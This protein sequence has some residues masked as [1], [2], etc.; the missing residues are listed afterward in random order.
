MHV[1]LQSEHAPVAIVTGASSG[2][3]AASARCLAAAGFRVVLAAR[4]AAELERI[5]KEI[6]AAGG[7][8]LPIPVDLAD[9]TETRALVTAT[10]EHHARIDVLVNNA[11]YGPAAA[12]EQLSRD[13]LRH[14]FEVNL[15][16]AL[17]LAG[18]VAPIMRTQGRGRIINMG[19]LA[20]AIPAPLA[21]AYSA[22]KAGLEVA[23]RGLRLELE[24]FG[25]DVVQIVP[26]FVDTP[27]FD[28]S[29][30]ASESLRADLANPYRQRMIDL[31]A[32][33]QSNMKH[34]LAPEAIGRIVLRAATAR[35]PKPRY[36]APASARWQ[37]MIFGVLPEGIAHRMLRRV[38]NT[39]GGSRRT[40]KRSQ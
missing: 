19:S 21:V 38:Y 6:E 20:A 32:F 28:K 5:A 29:R 15:L 11:G 25:I 24:P 22:T 31:D 27:T 30:A 8:A 12:N 1:R 36:Y 23:T 16:A 39:G 2:I 4:R 17:Q 34:A 13:D 35:R 9:A 18:G 33:A 26:G 40:P 7:K 37:S 10:M 14:A 3:G